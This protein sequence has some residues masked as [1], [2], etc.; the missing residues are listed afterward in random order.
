MLQ[1][2]VDRSPDDL[3]ERDNDRKSLVDVA[4]KYNQ[5]NPDVVVWLDAAI[6]RSRIQIV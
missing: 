4:R 1:F 5:K 6:D 3:H 2:F